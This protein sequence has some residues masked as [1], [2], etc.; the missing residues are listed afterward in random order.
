MKGFRLYVNGNFW[1]NLDVRDDDIEKGYFQY[2][3]STKPPYVVLSVE[4]VPDEMAMM[5]RVY[6]K[7]SDLGFMIYDDELYLEEGNLYL[8]S[9]IIEKAHL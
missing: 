3:V 7:K 5:K 8:K 6:F 2:H 1:K 9:K 4:E